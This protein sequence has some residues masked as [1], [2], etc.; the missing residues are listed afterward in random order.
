MG[1]RLCALGGGEP[2]EVE[3]AGAQLV[4]LA[5]EVASLGAHHRVGLA[6]PRLPVREH[7]A[8]V[9]RQGLGHLG[10]GR[11]LVHLVLR[12]RVLL[13]VRVCRRGARKHVLQDGQDKAAE[14]RSPR[15]LGAESEAAGGDADADA[16]A[17][18]GSA[19]AGVELQSK[20]QS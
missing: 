13:C 19:D 10:L 4:V 18:V 12:R 3:R 7:R 16:D 2:R 5:V 20:E 1:Y 8:V 17:G 6:A 15:R 9:A 14:Q 11:E